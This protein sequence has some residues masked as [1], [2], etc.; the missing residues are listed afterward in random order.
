MKTLPIQKEIIGKFNNLSKA[1]KTPFDKKNGIAYIWGLNYNM[2][3]KTGHISELGNIRL[4]TKKKPQTGNLFKDA[5]IGLYN[6]IARFFDAEIQVVDGKIRQI[7]KPLFSS[8][9]KTLE[10]IN[11]FL[12]STHENI[13]N[14]ESVEKKQLGVLCF[15]K[16]AIQRIQ[17]INAKLARKKGL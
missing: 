10:N 15:S 17:E 5:A 9:T 4:E 2:S 1:A 7:K 6:S 3:N 16:E 13:D 8:W 14:N 12:K 11:N